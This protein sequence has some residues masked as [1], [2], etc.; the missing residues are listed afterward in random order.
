MSAHRPLIFSATYTARLQEADEQARWQREQHAQ[1]KVLL[2]RGFYSEG[3]RA[4]WG[5]YLEPVPPPQPEPSTS[6]NG[7]VEETEGGEEER[8]ASWE[9]TVARQ[10]GNPRRRRQTRASRAPPD[11]ASTP[12]GETS[13][14][15]ARSMGKL[16]ASHGSSS[17]PIL[18]LF[19]LAPTRCPST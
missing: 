13:R 11:P 2:K 18:S 12:N 8:V 3:G 5:F 15:T 4:G 14:P 16:I 6:A 10:H 9:D 19:H 7:R 17:P 1:P